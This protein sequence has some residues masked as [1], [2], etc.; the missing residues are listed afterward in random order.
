MAGVR[1]PVNAYL[2]GAGVETSL[3]AHSDT[4][5]TFIIQLN[6]A[7]RWRLWHK[8]T[9]LPHSDMRVVGKKPETQLDI[10]R[11]GPPYIDVDLRQGQARNQAPSFCFPPLSGWKRVSPGVRV[12]TLAGQASDLWSGWCS[13]GAVHTAR[14]DPPHLD[15]A[16]QR[17]RGGGGEGLLPSHRGHG[18]VLQACEH[19]SQ[20]PRADG[21]LLVDCGGRSWLSWLAALSVCGED[22]RADRPLLWWLCSGG[23]A[24]A[25]DRLA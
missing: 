1:T 4:Q 18:E 17:R 19:P 22:M 9:L 25:L 11:L 12:Q 10:G 21:G 15:G 14:D 23:W 2:T 8:R 6:G 5:C 24:G 20:T 13:S 16:P 3:A 7:K